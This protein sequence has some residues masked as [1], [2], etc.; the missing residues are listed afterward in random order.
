MAKKKEQT[1]ME[2][3][4][5]YEKRYGEKVLA[6]VLGRYLSGWPD[7]PY[8]LWGLLIA[9]DGGFRFHHFPHEGWIQ[10][11][12]RVTTGG[13][14]PQEKTIFIPLER[15]R[16]AEI[17]LEKRWWKNLLAYQPPLLAIR[18]EDP[19]APDT[20]AEL[21]AEADKEGKKLIPF[22]TKGTP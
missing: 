1:R 7:Y 18:Y 2:F 8:P 14:P 4:A 17:R 21:L 19:Q 6:F 10:A 11:L 15:I 9:T 3:W 22:L 13:E 12:S 16:S 5:D 20:A